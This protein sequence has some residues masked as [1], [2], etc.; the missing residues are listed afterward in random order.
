M[1]DK[2]QLVFAGEILSGYTAGVVREALAQRLRLDDERLERMFSGERV[3][4]KR[5]V[6]LDRA[7]HYVSQLELL[8]A[9]LH[10]EDSPPQIGRAH[11]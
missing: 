9:L 3:V 7:L 4:L 1:H 6:E 2:F 11:V 8:G 10:I 5:G